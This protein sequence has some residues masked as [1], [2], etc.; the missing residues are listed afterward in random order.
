[1]SKQ[2]GIFLDNKCHDGRTVSPALVKI[3][4]LMAHARYPPVYTQYTPVCSLNPPA[5][6]EAS[7]E[8]HTARREVLTLGNSR[9]RRPAS[10][11]ASTP[12][13]GA[14]RAKGGVRVELAEIKRNQVTGGQEEEAEGEEGGEKK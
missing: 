14:V 10:P 8:S 3:K 11:G 7:C 12:P 5:S 13:E 6:R 4:H 2:I 1:M 9:Q